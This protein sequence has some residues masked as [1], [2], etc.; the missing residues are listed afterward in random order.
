MPRKQPTNRA[1]WSKGELQRAEMQVTEYV[2][3]C[4]TKQTPAAKLAELRRR[5]GID[6]EFRPGR[7]T[8][9]GQ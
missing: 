3:Q 2:Q 5:Y 8:E 4:L 7:V 9:Y 1:K 6:Y